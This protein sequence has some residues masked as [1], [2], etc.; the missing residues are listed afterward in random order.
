MTADLPTGP[1]RPWVAAPAGL[2]RRAAS[3]GGRGLAAALRP[4]LAAVARRGAERQHRPPAGGRPARRAAPRRPPAAVLPAAPRLDGGGRRG[5][6]RRAGAVGRLRGGHAAA[7]VGRRAPPGRPAGGPLGARRGG[8]VAVLGALRHRD[9]HVLAGHAA[10]A[11]SATC[12][13]LDALERP[14]W[15]CGW[16]ASPS[17]VG[18]AAADPLLGVLPAG[19]RRAC[20]WSLRAWRR[21]GDRAPTRPGAT[22]ARGRRWRCCSCPWLGGFLYQAPNTGTPWGAPFRPTAIVQTTLDGH[23]RRRPSP[24]PPCTAR[25]CWSSRWSRCSRCGRPGH[26]MILDLRTAPDGALGAGRSPS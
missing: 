18:P 20:C 10:G 24:R 13:S 25:W 3:C 26:E 11:R 1:R 21:P 23:G 4:A 8:A 12:C 22:V 6:R 15:P 2:A 9:P 7:G 16:S 19:G 5:R 17:I 14:T